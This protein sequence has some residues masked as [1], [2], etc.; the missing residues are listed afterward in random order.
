MFSARCE[1]AVF[2]ADAKSLVAGAVSCSRQ[3]GSD[4]VPPVVSWRRYV[5]RNEQ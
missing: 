1:L 3:T 5:K 4:Q 2:G